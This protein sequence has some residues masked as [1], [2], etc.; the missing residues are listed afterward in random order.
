MCLSPEVQFGLP[1]AVLNGHLT[2]AREYWNHLQEHWGYV[3]EAKAEA[4]EKCLYSWH[5]PENKDIEGYV[6]CWKNELNLLKT[7]TQ[8]VVWSTMLRAF[9][10]GLL[11]KETLLSPLIHQMNTLANLG[12]THCTYNH[13]LYFAQE[14]ISLCITHEFT[15]LKE[16]VEKK[17]KWRCWDCRRWFL[18]DKCSCKT[19]SHTNTSTTTSTNTKPPPAHALAS[20]ASPTSNTATSTPMTGK[21]TAS[22]SSSTNAVPTT[23]GNIKV[24][25][26][27]SA[28]VLSNP[29]YESSTTIGDLQHENLNLY[30]VMR[31]EYLN[32]LDSAATFH[33]IKDK[34]HFITF[35]PAGSRD[36]GTANCGILQTTGM[37]TC[38]FRLPIMDST[39]I[40]VLHLENCLHAPDAPFNLFLGG[41]LIE[42]GF[43]I[44]WVQKPINP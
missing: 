6:N 19:D 12:A 8:P 1:V 25:S 24:A 33:L 15:P 38:L 34:S 5:A 9:V 32:L 3:S 17:D 44:H 40:I 11:V 16:Q 22:K 31:T 18:G 20:T 7:S 21:P 13:F 36:V 27:Y 42:N 35:D 10:K 2:T 30:S 14:L 4:L 37:G 39:D 43:T 26:A 23:S 28:C 41:F 29:V